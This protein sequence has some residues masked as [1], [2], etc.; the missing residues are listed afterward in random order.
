MT[1]YHCKTCK[2]QTT[3]TKKATIN[4]YERLVTCSSCDTSWQVCFSCN[5]RWTS[6]KISISAKH[7]EEKHSENKC[8]GSARSMQEKPSCKLDTNE[9]IVFQN[10]SLENESATM[11]MQSTNQIPSFM[12]NAKDPNLKNSCLPFTSRR[13]FT[14]NLVNKNNGIRNIVGNAFLKSD[15]AME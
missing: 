9:T 5:L 1:I 4:K 6:R 15:Y 7:F 13:F 2:K 14:H 11:I 8:D 10:D 12:K 3:V